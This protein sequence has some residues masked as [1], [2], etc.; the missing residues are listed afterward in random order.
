MAE[1]WVYKG[2][3]ILLGTFT[4]LWKSR[5]TN[6]HVAWN[7][8]HRQC[9]VFF[10][11]QRNVFHTSYP[12]EFKIIGLFSIIPIVYLLVTP[13]E[14]NI[15][16][17]IYCTFLLEFIC[18]IPQTLL[19]LINSM[20]EQLLHALTQR[21]SIHHACWWNVWIFNRFFYCY[22]WTECEKKP[23]NLEEVRWGI[24]LYLYCKSPPTSDEVTAIFHVNWKNW[25]ILKIH[26]FTQACRTIRKS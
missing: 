3:S 23:M 4:Q 15:F 8:H 19:N 22:N 26:L 5:L 10:Y 14:I 6:S 16:K 25:V 20:R 1:V 2:I 18:V 17:N 13:L 11:S 21:G 7:C 12:S 9:N 24:H